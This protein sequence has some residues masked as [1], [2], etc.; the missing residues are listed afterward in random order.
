MYY[1]TYGPDYYYPLLSQGAAG[2]GDKETFIAAAHKLN[3]PY[4]QVQEFNREFGPKDGTTN[5]HLYFAMGQY[6]PI[7]DY[8]QLNNDTEYVNNKAAATKQK[9]K[10]G[11]K[12]EEDPDDNPYLSTPPTQFASHERDNSKYNYDYHLYKS[13]S[14]FFL[15]ANWPKYYFQ[16]LFTTDERGPVD[17]KGNRR[18]LYGNEL[19]L[20]L[21]SGSISGYDFELKVIEQLQMLFCT[22]PKFDLGMCLLLKVMSEG[23]FV[24]KLKNRDC[25]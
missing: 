1:N 16:Q 14:L 6:D 12:L 4:Y 10:Q 8:I 18:R 11:D 24:I 5:K 22:T 7:I 19:K 20:E 15:H 21:S 25:F 23:K 3:L 17:N 13:S 9:Q 2:E